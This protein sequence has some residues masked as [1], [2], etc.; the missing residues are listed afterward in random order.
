MEV[1]IKRTG[2]LPFTR[3]ILSRLV[4][5]HFY[6]Y[7]TDHRIRE[8]LAAKLKIRRKELEAPQLTSRYR[9]N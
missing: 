7:R 8:R 9:P 5:R 4:Y 3:G 6:L 2:R 1:L